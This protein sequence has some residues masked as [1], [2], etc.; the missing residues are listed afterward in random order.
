MAE[1]TD[2]FQPGAAQA[3][4]TDGYSVSSVHYHHTDHFSLTAMVLIQN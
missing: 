3:D 2:S 1:V 4:S